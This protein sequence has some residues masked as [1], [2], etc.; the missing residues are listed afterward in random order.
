MSAAD[1]PAG[2][3]GLICGPVSSELKHC[4]T[5]VPASL[6][7]LGPGEEKKLPIIDEY[8]ERI[9]GYQEIVSGEQ[10]YLKSSDAFL[11]CVGPPVARN[12]FTQD[13]LRHARW[14]EDWRIEDSIDGDIA[15]IYL[16][17]ADVSKANAALLA[18]LTDRTRGL[19]GEHLFEC[20]R[21]AKL[22][23][24]RQPESGPVG[25]VVCASE[26]TTASAIHR[27]LEKGLISRLVIGLPLAKIL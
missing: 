17:K 2:L 3:C 24:A 12:T 7:W 5:G 20:A 23:A 22:S 8:F 26:T 14:P 11:T 25:V 19:T 13:Y 18:K 9:P 15:G 4:L 21:R 10:A 27:A 16:E 1:S 6:P